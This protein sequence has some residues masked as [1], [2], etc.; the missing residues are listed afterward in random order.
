M[1]IE[2]LVII[3][4]VP[5]YCIL[6]FVITLVNQNKNLY[7]SNT[8]VENSNMRLEKKIEEFLN[9]QTESQRQVADF[10]K[11]END[12]KERARK[13]FEMK[14]KKELIFRKCIES[15]DD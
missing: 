15:N 9:H 10:L 4:L 5:I 1:T 7:R 14:R 12:R 13:E 8:R 3:I 6:I 11:S 2:T